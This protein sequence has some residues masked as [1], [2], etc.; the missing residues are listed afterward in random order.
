M[1]RQE[2]RIE[3]Q[4]DIQETFQPKALYALSERLHNLYKDGRISR[5]DLTELTD[6]ING[7]FAKANTIKAC[8]ELPAFEPLLTPAT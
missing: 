3:L 6:T 2:D 5:L 4:L 7:Q 1:S 8:M